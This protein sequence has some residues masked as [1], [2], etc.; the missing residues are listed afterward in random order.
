MLRRS[1][2]PLAANGLLRGQ[3]PD[4][5]PDVFAGR[6]KQALEKLAGVDGPEAVYWR[7]RALIADKRPAEAKVEADNGFA[8]WPDAAAVMTARGM[9]HFRMGE[10]SGAEEFF[11]RAVNKAG[12]FTYARVGMGAVFRAVS[13]QESATSMTEMAIRE[14]PDD[15]ALMLQM[16][17]GARDREG[18]LSWLSKAYERMEPSTEAAKDL[19]AH[20]EADQA[21]GDRTGSRLTSPYANYE[22]PLLDAYKNYDTRKYVR[23]VINGNKPVRLLLDSCASGIT[24]AESYAKKYGLEQLNV[25]NAGELRGIGDKKPMPLFRY[26]ADS[27]QAGGVTYANR[28][29][30]VARRLTTDDEA[31]VIG[32]D[33][34]DD[35][36]ITMD[37]PRRKLYL[38]TYEEETLPPGD[39]PIEASGPPRPGFFRFFRF[40]HLLMIPVLVG[41]EMKRGL[42]LIDTGAASILLSYEFGKSNLFKVKKTDAKLSGAQGTVDR[43]YTAENIEL[44]FGGFKYPSSTLWS[45][46]TKKLSDSIGA[47]MSGIL[48]MRILSQLE[49]TIDYRRGAARFLYK[50]GK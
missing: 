3:S 29:V 2:L 17:D 48:G 39:R 22:I 34:F 43:A 49:V 4:A 7:V 32:T 6:Y 10:L 21:M 30:T 9:V 18:H 35:F 8:K 5:R 16:A 11:R 24:L 12:G 36:V 33:V 23:A 46:E 1:F 13:M 27:V 28:T 50:G 31:G 37:F 15:P 19:A 42:F 25:H 41:K 26:R 44:T 47:E 40:G 14:A 20:I 38:R 45:F